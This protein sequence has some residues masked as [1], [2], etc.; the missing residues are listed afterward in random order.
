MNCSA[1]AGLR[2]PDS[3]PPMRQQRLD[4]R[5]ASETGC[6]V[7]SRPAPCCRPSHGDH[8]LCQRRYR[9]GGEGGAVLMFLSSEIG[10]R[11]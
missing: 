9:R 8:S 11:I 4:A 2:G 1:R 10:T 7:V 6:H 3:G 5:T